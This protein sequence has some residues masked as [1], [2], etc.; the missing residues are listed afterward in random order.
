[1]S[2]RRTSLLGFLIV[3]VGCCLL[4]PGTG[5]APAVAETAAGSPR[6]TLNGRVHARDG[7]PVRATVFIATAAPKSGYSV[8]CPSCYADCAKRAVTDSQGVFRIEAL[9][10]SLTFQVLAVAQGY[11]PRYVDGIDP[12]GSAVDVALD[13]VESDR[14]LPDRSLRGRVVDAQGA[15]IEGAVVAVLGIAREAGRTSWGGTQ[16]VDPRAVTDA[17]GRFLITARDPFLALSVTVTARAFADRHFNDL[18]AGAASRD[19]MLTEG[20]VLTGR[21]VSGGK[22]CGGVRVGLSGVDRRSGVWAGHREIG[23]D[24]EGRFTL[25]NLPP[26][27][28]YNLYGLLDA[29]K[30]YGAIAAR[31]IHAGADGAITEA[32]D[33][34]VTPGHHVAGRVALSD[35][36]PLPPD[37]RLLLGRWIAWDNAELTLGKEGSFALA[38]VPA[39]PIT[40]NLRVPG[41]LMSPKNACLD[42]MRTGL[43]GK[44]DRDIDDLLILL[45]PG[46]LPLTRIVKFTPPKPGESPV[47]RPLH[48]A[49]DSL[50]TTADRGGPR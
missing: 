2:L 16:G 20:A 5:L 1:L 45:D 21:V 23:T 39:E 26:D 34:V 10:P 43:M 24:E 25:F 8:F 12:A 47:D 41:Y 50:S 7:A 6:L 36:R 37:T 38:D 18:P 15:P 29:A 14:A 19:L 33:L 30:P 44:L 4:S 35:G 11:Q 28:D 46:E 9:D 31:Q 27:T 40:L 42:Q 13:P 17:K 49:E 3:V 32:G 48:G 22:P